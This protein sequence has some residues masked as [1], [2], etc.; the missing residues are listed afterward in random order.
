VSVGVPFKDDGKT[1]WFE[2]QNNSDLPMELTDGPEGAPANLTL[3]ANS[4]VIVKADRHFI[5]QPLKYSVSN[6]ITGNGKVLAVEIKI[7]VQPAK[8]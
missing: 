8:K 3:P 2:L 1:V 7:P 6:I 4:V 5:E